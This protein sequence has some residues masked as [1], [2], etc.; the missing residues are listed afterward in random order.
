MTAEK[1]YEEE[2]VG[3]V[4]A[5]LLD[6]YDGGTTPAP[7]TIKALLASAPP[8]V[9]A[10]AAEFA[11]QSKA[12]SEHSDC[13]CLKPDADVAWTDRAD[14]GMTSGYWEVT[15]MRCAKCHTPWIRAFIE[16]E[17]FPRSGRFYRAPTTDA[18]LDGVSPEVGMFIIEDSEFKIA[19]G[20]HFDGVEHVVRGHGP[21]KDSP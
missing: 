17:A 11:R 20:S 14:I 5:R 15:R 4:P 8:E 6:G 9:R 19:G 21:L 2:A 18:A 16:Y 3:G 10:R 13:V 1:K 12:V 7:E